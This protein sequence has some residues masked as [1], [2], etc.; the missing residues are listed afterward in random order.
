MPVLLDYVRHLRPVISSSFGS[1]FS[2]NILDVKHAAPVSFQV[3]LMHF[4]AEVEYIYTS[5]DY[6]CDNEK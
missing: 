3:S 1:A 2:R 4:T 6:R 5:I